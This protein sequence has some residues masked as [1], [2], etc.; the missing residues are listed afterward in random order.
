M[1]LDKHGPRRVTNY[2]E[3]ARFEFGDWYLG[4][5]RFASDGTFGIAGRKW[6]F[7]VQTLAIFVLG[8]DVPAL[9][10]EGA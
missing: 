8:A 4:E 1:R 7:V 3:Y 5:V 2:P 6:A 9:L 10:R